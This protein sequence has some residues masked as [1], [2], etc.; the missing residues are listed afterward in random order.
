MNFREFTLKNN[1][2][3]VNYGAYIKHD[4]SDHVEDNTVLIPAVIIKIA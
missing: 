3:Q 2:L 1:I 4:T